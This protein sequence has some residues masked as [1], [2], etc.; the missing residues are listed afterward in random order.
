MNKIRYA[1]TLIPTAV[2]SVLAGWEAGQL[3]S[4]SDVVPAVLTVLALIAEIIRELFAGDFTEPPE[5][6]VPARGANC[7]I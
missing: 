7:A 5:G 3:L 1:L 4:T 2:A 6:G